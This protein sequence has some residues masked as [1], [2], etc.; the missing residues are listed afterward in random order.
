[1]TRTIVSDGQKRGAV[2]RRPRFWLLGGLALALAVLA[3]ILFRSASKGATDGAHTL[4]VGDQR[5]GAQALLKAAGELDDVPY[6]IKWALFPAASP[7]LE[8]LDAGA[9]DIGGIGGAP[10]AFAYASGAQIRAVTA[11]RPTGV[12]AG[13]ASAIVVPKNSPIESLADLRGKK[14]ATIRGSAGQD[15]VLRL[16]ERADINPRSIRW[17]YLSNGESK[18]ALASGAIDAWSTWGSYVGIA[19]LEDG[20]RIL[21]D[22]ANLPTGAGFY[23]ANDKAIDQ[24]RALLADYV[25]RL[26]R[27]RA[28][29]RD[30]LNDYARVLAKETGIPVEVARFAA[31]SNVGEAVPIDAVLV[32]EQGRIFERYHAAGIIPDIPRADKGYDGSFNRQVIEATRRIGI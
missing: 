11:Y 16:L 8:A 9:I 25:A 6:Q 27:A 32:R 30:H 19:I 18:A 29:A 23:A 24:K 13:K 31:R 12:H 10:F 2:H 4:V 20:D 3:F 28:W 21:A 1:M 15:L 17:T 26:A 7:L 14:V 5:G 22:G